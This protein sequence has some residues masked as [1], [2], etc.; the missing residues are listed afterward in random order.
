MATI[1]REKLKEL[2]S[3]PRL[4]G[5]AIL[6]QLGF[7]N[8]AAFD[9]ALDKDPE[10]RRIFNDGRAEAKTAK[11]TESTSAQ[12]AVTRTGTKKR[13][14]GKRSTSKTPPQRECQRRH[15]QGPAQE[16]YFGI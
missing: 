14:K 16:N 15:R 7:K 11:A 9:Y 4:T 2:A 5:K 10:A 1:V 13:G 3:D 6:E 12:S 8:Y